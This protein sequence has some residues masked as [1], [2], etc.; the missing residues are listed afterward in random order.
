M[1]HAP[2]TANDGNTKK[3]VVAPTKTSGISKTSKPK[4]KPPKLPKLS[5]LDAAAQI[6]ESRGEA[7][8][9]RDL[10]EAMAKQGLWKSPGGK[11]P[12][13]TL[14]AAMNRKITKLGRASR[15]KKV[16]RGLFEFVG[17]RR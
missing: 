4:S 3:V 17:K 6:L 5:A 12:D 10:I 11:T 9:A 15:F 2:K 1:K 16:D 13:A 7:M 14:S 8:R